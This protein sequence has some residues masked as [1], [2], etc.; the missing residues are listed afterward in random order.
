VDLRA[1]ACRWPRWWA[2]SPSR[3]SPRGTASSR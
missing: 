3:A 1:P 2:S